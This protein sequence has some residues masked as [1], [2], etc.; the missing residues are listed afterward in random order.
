MPTLDDHI[1]Q[2]QHNRRCLCTI[3]PDF[4][5]WQITVAFYTALHAVDTLLS[6]DKVTVTN[7]EG[8]NRTL[9]GTNR[10]EKVNESY[11]PL[12]NLS[13][14]VR[15]LAQPQKWVPPHHIQRQVV[16]RYVYPI[17][18]SVQKLIGRD[19]TLPPIR[20]LTSGV[21]GD[22]IPVQPLPKEAPQL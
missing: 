19:L 17:E 2:W 11:Q 5:D 9:A 12:Y 7:H 13:R 8:R 21:G 18:R 15:Y 10:Y 14:V 16:E 20:I 4:S 6:F 22:P 3:A 1:R